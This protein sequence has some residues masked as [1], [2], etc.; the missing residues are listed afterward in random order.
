MAALFKRVANQPSRHCEQSEGGERIHD[1]RITTGWSQSGRH[2][3]TSLFQR[4]RKG[5]DSNREAHAP[6]E[7]ASAPEGWRQSSQPSLIQFDLV[8]L[9]S[10]L[11]L[12]C[13]SGPFPKA[14]RGSVPLCALNLPLRRTLDRVGI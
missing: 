2:L 3:L 7:G 13:S 11:P 12:P 8:I 4:C 6:G 1:G 9:R 10:S 14:G 5:N